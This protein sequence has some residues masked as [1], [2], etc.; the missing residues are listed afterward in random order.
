MVQ[1]FKLY[2]LHSFPRENYFLFAIEIS[3][4]VEDEQDFYDTAFCDVQ[5]HIESLE[6]TKG[7]I[8]VF[9]ISMLLE[10]LSDALYRVEQSMNSHHSPPFFIIIV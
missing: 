8:K 1:L 10:Q 2:T 3:I 6:I 7:L 5:K 4:F 9:G